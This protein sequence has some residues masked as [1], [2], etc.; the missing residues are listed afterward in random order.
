MTASRNRGRPMAYKLDRRESVPVAVKRIA[1]QQVQRAVCELTDDRADRHEAVHQSRKRFK[2]VRAVLRLVR[3][4]LG[5]V[6]TRENAWYRDTAHRLSRVRDAEAMIETFDRLRQRFPDELAG[7]PSLAIR[8]LLKARRAR[9]AQEGVCLE[10]VVE[11]VVADLRS[12]RK[13][14]SAWPLEEDGL[15]ALAS[16][17]AK[18]YRRGRRG[19]RKAYASPSDERFH[20]WRKRVKYHWYHARVLRDIWPRILNGR[21]RELS[22]LCDLLGWEHDLAVFRLLLREPEKELTGSQHIQELEELAR[23]RQHELRAEAAPLGRK[24][25]AEKPGALVARLRTYFEVWKAEL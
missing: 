18:T 17:L 24:L 20:E 22:R 5:D 13:R 10:K 2:K 14:V 21:C 19:L 12:A 8:E 3:D 23:V 6:Y 4:E 7:R 25:F 15:D 16:G 11:E 9:I 1:R